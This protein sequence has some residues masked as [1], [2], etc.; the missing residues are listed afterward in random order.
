MTDPL[1]SIER[2]AHAARRENAPQVDVVAKVKRTIRIGELPLDDAPFQWIALG[3]SVAAVVM[4]MVL[5]PVYR[6]WSDPVILSILDI[7]WGML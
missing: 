7:F 2:L 3:A 5:F 1:L 6:T 4:I